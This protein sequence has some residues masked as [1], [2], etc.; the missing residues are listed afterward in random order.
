MLLKLSFQDNY[1][2]ISIN[3]INEIIAVYILKLIIYI[4]KFNIF[5][6]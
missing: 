2:L 5:Q 4:N 3:K 6:K 1:A